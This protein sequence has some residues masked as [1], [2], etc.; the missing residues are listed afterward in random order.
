VT[1][2]GKYTWWEEAKAHERSRK[3][4]ISQTNEEREEIEFLERVKTA[5]V[6]QNVS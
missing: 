6:P 2:G 4:K 3:E 5:G 1:V